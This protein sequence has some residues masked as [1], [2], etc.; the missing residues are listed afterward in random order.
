MS[1]IRILSDTLASQVAAGEVVERPAAVVRELVENS[2]DAGATQ[3]EVAVQSGGAALIRVTDNG[4]GMDRED[5][6][7]CLERHATSKIKTKDDLA[8]IH[9]FGFRGEALPS[10]ASVS[11]FRLLTCETGAPA[12]TELEVHGGKLIAVRD[13]VAAAGSMI[14]VRSLF[15]NVPARRKF[16]RTEATEYAQVEQQFR[17][18]AIANSHASFTLIKD[19]AVMHHLPATGDVMERIRGLVGDELAQR[20][21]PVPEVERFGIGIAGYIGGPGFSRSNRQLQNVFLNGRAIESAAIYHGLREGYHT[22][23]MKGQ[24][25]VTFL[26]M[27]MDPHAYDI[28]VHPAK[29]EVRF[30]DAQSVREAL[31]RAIADTLNQSQALPRGHATPRAL[32]PVGMEL[33]SLDPAFSEQQSHLPIAAAE[34]T[35]LRRDWTNLP[36]ARPVPS[37]AGA[38]PS[39]DSPARSFTSSPSSV[40]PSAPAPA[41][42]DPSRNDSPKTANA[43]PSNYRIIGV[44]NQLYVLLESSEGLVLMD[45]HAAHER[46]LFEKLRKSMETE[47]VP[48]QRLLLPLMLHLGPRDFEILC[49]NLPALARLG[50]EAEPFGANTLKIDALPTFLT[51]DDPLQLMNSF[52]EELAGLSQRSSTLRLGEDMIATTACRHAVKAN[53]RLRQP[54]L[55]SL[56]ASLLAC[57]MPYCCP[58]GR[59]TLIQISYAELDRKFGRRAPG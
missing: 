22:A 7:M 31:S 52:V 49:R 38:L 40:S 1:K 37:P 11:R 41:G 15:Y 51:S 18:H 47:G 17:L 59:P 26:F 33:P 13:G 25:P 50:I 9:T 28:N 21:L 55:Q 45:Q 27:R 3:I 4:A 16:L 6:M 14:E 12:G 54:E 42:T 19:G 34:Q 24:H 20:L 56:L 2:L 46:V 36:P 23:L 30:H 43:T 48:T 5:A 8:A 32:S 53:D 57:E 35:A 10:I 44:L 58:H 29:K 39:D